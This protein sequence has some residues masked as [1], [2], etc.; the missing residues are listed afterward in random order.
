ME[1]VEFVKM[2]DFE[3]VVEMGGSWSWELGFELGACHVATVEGP[4]LMQEEHWVIVPR[5]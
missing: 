1:E 3:M 4:V 5:R 2:A